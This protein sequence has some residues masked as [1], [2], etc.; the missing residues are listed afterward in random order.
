M[1]GSGWRYAAT[2]APVVLGCGETTYDLYE[3]VDP[4]LG[5][6]SGGAL[7]SASGGDTNQAAP[8][9]G[10]DGIGGDG[11]TDVPVECQASRDPS[12]TLV[13]LL[14]VD[15]NL[16][17]AQGPATTFLEQPGYEIA[18][19][20]CTEDASQYWTVRGLSNGS[21]ELRN[22]GTAMNLDINYS[23]TADGTPV[24]LFTPHR[25]ENQR[26]FILP[27]SGEAFLLAPDNAP[28][29][30]VEARDD[31]LEIWPCDA[32]NPAQNFKQISC[33]GQP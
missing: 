5:T 16:C 8:D 27:G 24:V 14:A 10:S 18:L 4:G 7:L 31:S 29:Q 6:S 33:L 3:Q 20:P 25:L 15:R 1:T 12:L 22:E 19:G 23:N 28:W 9:G 13:R 32:Q 21:W 26:F 17:V 2:L 30:C 11:S